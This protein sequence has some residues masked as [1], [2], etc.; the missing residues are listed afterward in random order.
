M[1][2]NPMI[3][4][5]KWFLIVL[6]MTLLLAVAAPVLAD[7]VKGKIKSITADKREFTVTDNDG[8]NHEF[9]LNE[10]GKVKLGDKDGKLNDLKEGAEVTITY[11]KKDGKMMVSEIK[12]KKE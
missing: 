7:E 4:L 6:A 10:D 5:P 12:C 1:E 2:G 11:E 8:K 9:I 3:R